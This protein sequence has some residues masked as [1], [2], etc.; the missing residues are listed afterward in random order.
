MSNTCR[1]SRAI[2]YII[3]IIMVI[4]TTIILIIIT[5]IIVIMMTNKQP[6]LRSVRQ[7]EHLLAVNSPSWCWA[8]FP[9]VV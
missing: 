1:L 9:V 3:T 8:A 2:Y 7:V 4:I 5:T 6:A